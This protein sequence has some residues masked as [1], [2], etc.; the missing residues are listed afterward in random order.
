MKSTLKLIKRFCIT[1]ILA[2]VLLFLLNVVLLISVSYRQAANG[3]GWSAAEE[4]AAG[5]AKGENGEYALSQEGREV[6]QS[7]NAWAILIE[8]GTGQVVWHS[9][10]LPG[11]VPLH[12]S[13]SDISQATRG[14][15]ADYP[16]TTGACGDDLVILGYPRTAYWKLMWNTFDYEM[17]A[18]LPRTLLIFFMANCALVFL[19]YIAATS[20]VVRAV[21]PVLKGIEALPE[22]GEVYLREKGLLSDLATAINR[23]SEKLRLQEKELKRRENARACW[24]AGV[25]HDIR[26]PLSMVMG[27]AEQLE[28]NDA[29]PEKERKK[30]GIIRMQSVRMKNLVNDLNLSSRL[31]YH[32]QPLR[33]E[34]VNLVAAVRQAVV[35]FMNLDLEG[36]FPV[37]WRTDE[38]LA[39]CGAE[40]DGELIR[41]AVANILMNSQV[42]N[43]GGCRITAEVRREGKEA[44]LHF[45]DDGAGVTDVQLER[46]RGTAGC[47]AENRLHGLGLRIVSQIAVAHQGTVSF[48]HGS[49]G[50]FAVEMRFLLYPAAVL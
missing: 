13:V 23:A 42:H 33:M 50:G 18:S 48:S 6:L 10:N 37:D 25:S 9:E 46:L 22:G 32:M 1:L 2:V 34:K 35:D 19:I 17:I 28:E 8:N 31:E 45:E 7:G 15:I 5:L 21:R 40:C 12:Y 39:V 16:T 49:R 24:I 47:L 26:T 3:S 44:V 27:Y 14:Y 4:V 30:A 20:G 11:G 43:P 41:R 36:K 29:L 38:R